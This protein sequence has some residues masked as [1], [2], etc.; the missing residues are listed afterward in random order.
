MGLTIHYTLK[1]DADEP[2]EARTF[3]A[4]LQSK[5][6]DLPFQ[7][8]G[9]LVELAGADCDYERLAQ[10]DPLRW[11]LIQ[12]GRHLEFDQSDGSR[13]M[14]RVNPVHLIAFA[15]WPGEGCEEANLGLCRY[16]PFVDVTDPRRPHTRQLLPTNLADH[17]HW[18]SFCKTQYASNPALG[19]VAHFLR[20]HVS[21]IRLLDFAKGV[22]LSIDVRDEGGFWNRR[23][24]AALAREVGQWNEFI[25][26]Q[27]GQF[28]DLLGDSFQAAI[29]EFPNFEHLEAA[30]DRKHGTQAPG[31]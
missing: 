19:G 6:R 24:L 3:V 15:T 30:G 10:D 29:A 14:C 9:D 4:Q 22:G 13:L 20:C 27:V 1:S 12:A 8:V 17:W 2:Q 5:A 26:R 31:V 25:A 16:A 18:S 21:L 23:D 7:E 28:K 11:L